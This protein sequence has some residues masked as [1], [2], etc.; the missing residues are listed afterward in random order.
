MVVCESVPTTVSG[1]A[2]PPKLKTA[3]AR[4]SRFTWWT[5]P[6][7]GGTTRKLRKADWPQRRNA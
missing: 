5:M 6:V 7:S 2:V 3:G 4:H 1:Y